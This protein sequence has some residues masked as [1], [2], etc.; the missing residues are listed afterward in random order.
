LFEAAL[1]AREH[2]AEQHVALAIETHQPHPF[3]RPQSYFST[4]M[5]VAVPTGLT[6]NSTSSL[7]TSRLICSTVLG[8]L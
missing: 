8:G 5:L 3:D 1:L 4:A 7:S 2:V 6:R